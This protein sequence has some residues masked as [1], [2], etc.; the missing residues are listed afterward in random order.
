MAAMPMLSPL[1]HRG[2]GRALARVGCAALLLAAGAACAQAASVYRC[3]GSHGEVEY[4][5]TPCPAGARTHEVEVTPQPLIGHPDEAPPA[6]AQPTRKARGASAPRT[7]RVGSKPPKPPTAFE[8]R[9]ANGEVFYR[10]AR[11]PASVPGDGVLRVDYAERAAA[12]N[13]RR[14]GTAWDR[15]PVR[16]I[17]VPRAEACRRIRA[18]GAAGRDGHRRDE[19]VS[20]YDRAMGR[21][22]CDRE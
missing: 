14:R 21:D 1:P 19:R 7:P 5:D 15:V 11:C 3:A 4:R 12:E 22:P 16:G 10:H 6:A 20:A 9:A 8:C 18:A 17:A 2:A 13:P